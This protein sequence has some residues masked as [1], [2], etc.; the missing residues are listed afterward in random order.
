MVNNTQVDTPF[1]YE[2]PLERI[3]QRPVEPPEAAKMLVSLGGT[4]PQQLT[5]EQ[6]PQVLRPGDLLVFN[7]TRVTPARLRGVIE[8]KSAAAEF[9]LVGRCGDAQWRSLAKPLKKLE[10]GTAVICGGQLRVV[11]EERVGEKEVLLSISTLEVGGS[12][13][14]LLDREGE[15]PIPPYI[16]RG[17]ADHRDRLDYQSMF[18]KN[19]GSIAAPTASLHFSPKLMKALD[20]RGVAHTGLTLHLGIASFLPVFFPENAGTLVPPAS[21]HYVHSNLLLNRIEATR[22]QGGRVIA[23]GTSVVRALESMA[24]YAAEEGGIRESSLFITPGFD[25]RALD[26]IIT[27]FHQPG[28]THLLLVEAYVGK[29]KL[30]ELYDCALKNDFRFLSYGD[31]MILLPA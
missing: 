9:L 5:F 6:L 24:R 19:P 20:A 4:S 14:E 31:G 22:A 7:E 29:E 11:V 17:K 3:A 2:L 16:R 15:M 1:I 30:A 28:T 18:A 10:P 21:E 27:N 8:G 25:F 23:V 26:G 12:L 13:D